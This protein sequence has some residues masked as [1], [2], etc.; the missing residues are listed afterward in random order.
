MDPKASGIQQRPA[1]ALPSIYALPLYTP[2]KDDV[3]VYVT[4]PMRGK[5]WPLVHSTF[6][7]SSS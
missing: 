4:F 7:Y 2:P 6:F 3:N 1:P 5:L